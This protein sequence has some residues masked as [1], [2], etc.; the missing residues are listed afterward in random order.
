[1]NTFLLRLALLTLAAALSAASPAA[2]DPPSTSTKAL[3]PGD[4]SLRLQVGGR[5]RHYLVHVPPGYNGQTP[6]PVVMMLHGGGGTSEAAAIETQWSAKADQAAF[7]V[8]FPDAL[9]PDPAKRSS[10]GRNP[11]LWNDGSERFYAGQNEVDD[12]GFLSAVLDDLSV[13]FAVDAQRLFVT[14][15]S[16]GASMAFRFGAEASTRVAAIAPVAGAC[17]LDP[18]VLP[19]PL[20]MLY[21]TGTADPLNPLAGGVP[22]LASGRSDKVRG[23]PKPP[24]HDSILKWARAAGCPEAPASTSAAGGIHTET[25]GPGRDG[26]EVVCLS[27]DDLGHTW[28]GGKSLLPESMVGKRSDKIRAT[29]VIWDFFV[30]HPRPVAGAGAASGPGEPVRLASG[31]IAGEGRH[32]VRSFKGIPFAAPPVGD[33]RWKPPQPVAPWTEPRACLAFG[34]A[35]PQ[36][37]KD[38][39]GPVG[40]QSE[41]CLYLNVWTPAD[42]PDA[43]LP[44]MVWIHGGG[45]MFGSGGKPCYEGAELARRGG[46]VVVT[47]NYRLG[48]FGFLAHPAL[49]AES[50]QRASGNYGM[51]DQIAALRWVQQSI[52]ACGGDPGCVTIFG[53]SAGGVSV[54]ALMASPLAK[55]LFHRAIVQSGSAPGK[56]HDRATMEACGVEFAQRL[57]AAD[58]PALRAQPAGALL[59][60][61]QPGSGRVGEGTLDHLCVDGYVL[62]ETP[63]TVFAA[64]R[65]INVP[66]LAGTTKDE[67]RLFLAGVQAVVQAMAAIQPQTFNYEF[68]RVADYAAAR[69]LGCFHGSELPYLFHYFPPL[70]QSN[71]ADEQLSDLVIGYW[72]RFART[73]DPGDAGVSTWPAYSATTPHVQPLDAGAPAPAPAV[74]PAAR[75]DPH[76]IV[77]RFEPVAGSGVSGEITLTPHEGRWSQGMDVAATVRGVTDP[78]AFRDRHL[79]VN[80]FS[81]PDCRFEASLANFYDPTDPKVEHMGVFEPQFWTRTGTAAYHIHPSKLYQLGPA[82]GVKQMGRWL[83][84]DDTPIQEQVRSVGILS[85]SRSVPQFMATVLA[86]ANLSGEPLQV[87]KVQTDEF[88]PREPPEDTTP[89]TVALS[90]VGD[91][92]VRGT[93]TLRPYEYQQVGQ[94]NWYRCYGTLRVTGIAGLDESVIAYLASAPNARWEARECAFF[95]QWH[96]RYFLRDGVGMMVNAWFTQQFDMPPGYRGYGGG[97]HAVRAR[98]QSVGI[99]NTKTGALLALGNVPPPQRRPPADAGR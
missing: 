71:A 4:H 91:S 95:D 73:G 67:D 50:P 83:G 39:Y 77:L 9:P 66:L 74:A 25:Y 36:Q 87:A 3:P 30:K 80:L 34:P 18:L 38:L 31:P 37:G 59:A 53:Q 81:E 19:R 33:L 24:V 8:V 98:M 90:P 92:G 88:E 5:E 86:G 12:V 22:R 68:R 85:Y 10:F 99:C 11:Q 52:A 43:R 97:W 70:L 62:P 89:V 26:A 51:M 82:G 46:V 40:E 64:G 61:V 94:D 79:I 23:K 27:V 48:P 44:V 2:P 54:C 49:T 35:C 76:A 32:G 16:N 57:G 42:R 84:R 41:D 78:G 14:G 60:A 47:C 7:L 63:G 17:W 69:T 96:S 58:L 21:I 20:P 15:F 13:R 29:D 93:I 6:V 1:M 75:R 72:T 55:G 56:L 65:Q 45:F 28:A